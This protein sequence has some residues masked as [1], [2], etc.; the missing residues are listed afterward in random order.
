MLLSLS[1]SLLLLVNFTSEYR[2]ESQ[3]LEMQYV[4]YSKGYILYA[5][6]SILCNRITDIDCISN[7]ENAPQA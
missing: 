2:N 6:T 7:I 1:V 3:T 5:Y 4:A